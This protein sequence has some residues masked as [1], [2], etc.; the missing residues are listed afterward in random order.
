MLT[1]AMHPSIA[2]AEAAVLAAGRN[3]KTDGG[4]LMYLGIILHKYHDAHNHLPDVAIRDREGKPL[5]SWRV[6]ILPFIDG[7]PE[8]YQQFHLDEPWDSE[9][10][11]K[12]IEKIPNVFRSDQ[13]A[14][15]HT[16]FLAP[17]GKGVGFARGKGGLSWKR[18]TDGTAFTILV[19]EADTDHA[20]VWTQPEDLQIDLDNPTRGITDG[21]ANFWLLLGGS[22][23]QLKGSAPPAVLRA[24]LTRD[25]GDRVDYAAF[26]RNELASENCFPE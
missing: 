17:V 7:G 21:D 13:T 19:V 3:A 2:R 18:F 11:H 9:H 24:L 8:L 26:K 14:E 6:A 22:A 10:N 15:G 12:L 25:A 20:V 4:R 5:L 1:R 16:R 23:H